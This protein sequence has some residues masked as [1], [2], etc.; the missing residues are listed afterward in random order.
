M[1]SIA[2]E[3]RAG[4]IVGYRVSLGRGPDGKDRRKFCKTHSLAQAY[5]ASQ[6]NKIL[7]EERLFEEKPMILHCMKRLADVGAT[8]QDATDFYMRHGASKI[9]PTIANAAE[10]LI[11]RKT[12]LGR[13]ELYVHMLNTA[14]IKFTGE[15]G[16]NTK[17]ADVTTEQIFDYVFV[18]NKHLNGVSQKNILR[19]LNVLFNYAVTKKMIGM[20]PLI[21]MDTPT[22]YNEMPAVIT[23]DDFT[24]L[25]NR[26]YN[27]KWYDRMTVF[28]LIGF[29]GIRREEACKLTWQ[30]INWTDETVTIPARIAK[31]ASFRRNK[32]PENAM[33]WL[34]AAR[35]DRLTN[36]IGENGKTLLRVALRFSHIKYKKNALRHSFCSY[37]LVDW[38]DDD[39][40]AKYMGHIGS[41]KMM[42]KHYRTLVNE[43][44]AKKWWAI[45]PPPP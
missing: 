15:V 26:C 24:S 14:L 8:L 16:H 23:P 38:N 11:E 19:A 17:L 32:I 43:S 2:P 9:N 3:I 20:N 25:L 22:V 27:K 21:G 34:R 5:L 10:A 45:S 39:K 4:K 13:N 33:R 36:L 31:G 35:D 42:Y 7:G 28:V 6:R 1:S 41:A 40:V 30:D 44:D 37:A 12:Q 29:C 18:K